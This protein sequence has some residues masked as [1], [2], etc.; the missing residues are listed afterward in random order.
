MD[1][2][3]QEIQDQHATFNEA[4]GNKKTPK[5]HE[6]M[7]FGLTMDKEDILKKNSQM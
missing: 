7:L 2:I 5:H 1:V 3:V 6:N 4:L